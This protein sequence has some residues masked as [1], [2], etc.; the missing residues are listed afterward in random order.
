MATAI[1][2]SLPRCILRSLIGTVVLAV[3]A[4]FVAPCAAEEAAPSVSFVNEVVPL[5][6]KAGCNAGIC[7]AKAGNGQ[8]GFQLSLLGFEPREDYERLVKEGRGRRIFP[9]SPENSLL[10]LKASGGLP[11]GGGIRLERDSPSYATLRDWIR[12]GAPWDGETAPQLVAVAVEPAHGTVERDTEQALKAIASYSDGSLRD[13]TKIA[14]Y[15]SNDSAMA[16]VTEEGVVKI[17]DIPGKVAVMVRYQGKVTVFNASVP[18]GAKVEAVPAIKNFVD[19]HVFANLQAIGV[20]PSPVCDD[21][22][23]LR[24]V[25]LDIAGRLPTEEETTAFFASNDADKRERLIDDLLRT[26]EYAD[27]FANKWTALLKNRRDDASDI[28]SNF[29]FFAWM[30]DNLLAN[31]PYNQIVR[32]LLAATGMVISNPPVAW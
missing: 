20:P 18:L 1:L 31:T 6:T 22:T 25:S 17:F 5:L 24:R 27:F 3:A 32:E 21:A 28:T 10:L 29:A 9:A 7:H 14:L 12:S 15:E 23:F 19:E 16:D 13:V 11:H 26:P 30:R 4:A 2:R 8:N